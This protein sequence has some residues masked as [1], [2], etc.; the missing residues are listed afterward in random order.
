MGTII[1]QF[2]LGKDTIHAFFSFV[3]YSLLHVY[4]VYTNAIES[5]LANFRNFLSENNISA[6]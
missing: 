6:K 4:C 2:L 1:S 5:K 3:S